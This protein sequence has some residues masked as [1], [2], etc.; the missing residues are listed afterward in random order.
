LWL[1]S[2]L[3]S[4]QPEKGIKSEAVGL[5]KVQ[6]EKFSIGKFVPQVQLRSFTA[7]FRVVDLQAEVSGSVVA[8]P[9]RRGSTVEKGQVICALDAEDTQ[10]QLNQSRAQ[11]QQ[12]EIAYSGALQLKTA[13]FQSELAIAKAKAN[14]EGAKLAV[15]RSEINAQNIRIKAP[16]TA[17]VEQRP[18]EK[19]DFLGV[20]QLCARLVELN[21]LKIIAR[22]SGSDV[23]KLKLGDRA[24]MTFDDYRPVEAYLT[25]IAHEANATTRNYLVEARAPN[26]DLTMRAGISG[27]LSL[28][29][30][31][32]EA[33]LIPSSL[34]LL[35]T[36]GDMVVRA[37]DKDNFVVQFKV[38]TVGEDKEGV[39][40][41]GLPKSVNLITV[42]QNYVSQGE[43]V[44]I[45][46]SDNL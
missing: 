9:G 42:G 4:T 22:A 1:V 28:N 31:E 21:P 23:A 45:Y 32:M 24:I 8:V 5:T 6:V 19:G 35:D 43:Q 7:P 25:Y 15:R 34:I 10:Q 13:G 3:L 44:E 12:A 14:L 2:G 38:T 37:V 26:T 46:F 27:I 18:V 17:I 30:P 29:L 11:L 39:W 41:Q 20:G 33:H 16:F 36:D 40:V